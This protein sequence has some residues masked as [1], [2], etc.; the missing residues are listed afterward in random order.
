M[1]ETNTLT[2]AWTPWTIAIA[3]AAV[4]TTAIIGL[5]ACRRTKWR[6]STVALEGLRFAMVSLAAMLLGGPEWV[7]EY[8][9]DEKPVVAVLWDDSASMRT[10]DVASA[11][12]TRGEAVVPLTRPEAWSSLNDRADVVIESFAESKRKDPTRISVQPISNTNVD[13]SPAAQ[14]TEESNEAGTDLASP[15][16]DVST[17]HENLLGVVLASDGD[18]NQGGAPSQAAARL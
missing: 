12:N 18:W 6:R 11:A 13:R 1:I 2:F 17:K 3:L 15:L 4:I 7:E 10:R 14:A 8:R 16:V 9:P 5:I